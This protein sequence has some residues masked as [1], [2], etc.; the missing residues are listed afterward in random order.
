MGLGS[1]MKEDGSPEE[2]RTK[3]Y[4]TESGQKHKVLLDQE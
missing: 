3:N 2:I 4:C 1:G